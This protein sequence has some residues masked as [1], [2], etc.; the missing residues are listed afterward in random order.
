LIFRS[1]SAVMNPKRRGHIQR[2]RPVLS[3]SRANLVASSE[4]AYRFS[5]TIVNDYNA[6]SVPNLS[7]ASSDACGVYWRA[8]MFA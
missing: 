5:A 8:V 4:S 6:C 1:G 3:G 7:M 2:F